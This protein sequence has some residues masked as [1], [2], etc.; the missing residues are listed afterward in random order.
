MHGWQ[1]KV[2]HCAM[3]VKVHLTTQYI[4]FIKHNELKQDT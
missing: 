2:A 3:K 4:N 1:Y